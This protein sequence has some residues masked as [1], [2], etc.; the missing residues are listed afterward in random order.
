MQLTPSQRSAIRHGGNN[1]QFIACAGSGKMEVLA[2]RVVYL[3]DPTNAN[4]PV[5]AN[6]IAFTFT[7]KA[8]AELQERIVTR[9]SDLPP[10]PV[11]RKCAAYDDRGRCTTA[12]ET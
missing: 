5:P 7:D 1:L 6:I 11:R 3:L 4:P 10:A 8:A 2:R 9:I 12:R